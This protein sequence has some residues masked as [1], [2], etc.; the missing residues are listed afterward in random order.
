LARWVGGTLT[1]VAGQIERVEYGNGTVT[2]KEYYTHNYRLKRLTTKDANDAIL[3]D[4][5]YFYDGVGNIVKIINY[6]NEVEQGTATEERFA[7]DAF[8]RL[9]EAENTD[10]TVDEYGLLTYQYDNI[11]NI[12]EKDGMAYTY[13]E[14]DAG[15]HAVT[16]MESQD[17]TK[18]DI[19]FTYDGNGNMLTKQKGEEISWYV[20]DVEN[21]LIE[22]RKDTTSVAFENAEPLAEYKYDGDG[23]RTEKTVYNEG[24]STTSIYIGSLF[25]KTNN[26]ETRHIYLGSERIASVSGANQSYTHTNHLG[27][28]NVVTNKN[29]EEIE[30]IEYKPY[31]QFSKHEKPLANDQSATFYFTGKKLDDETGLYFLGG[32]YYDSSLG[33]FITPD[34]LVP[35]PTDPQTLNRYSYCGGNPVNFTD[36]SGHFFGI[37]VAIFKV[38]VAIGKAVA[39]VANAVRPLY[40][41]YNQVSLIY[42]LASGNINAGQF[43]IGMA[44]TN[45]AQGLIPAPDFANAGLQ[46]LASAARGAA[47]GAARAAATGQD[48]G[49][50]ALRSAGF[51]AAGATLD[52]VNAGTSTNASQKSENVNSSPGA[53]N[54]IRSVVAKVE[55][56]DK[57]VKDITGKVW[58]LPNTALGLALGV[59]GAPFVLMSGQNPFISVGDNAINIRF[60]IG[61]GALT[62]GNVVLY[63]GTNRDGSLFGPETLNKRTFLS[64]EV[65]T[66]SHER[67]HTV[68]AQKRGPLYLPA[69]GV[70]LLFTGYEGHSQE[71][72]ADN[73]AVQNP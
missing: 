60:P 30:L 67:Q 54:A 59:A 69:Y 15:P 49:K 20:Y 50:A 11:G 41:L 31:G 13:G 36:P 38:A 61:A 21:R 43:F 45:V 27:S 57:F 55:A 51:S 68:Q 22:V 18:E 25:E 44:V 47:V 10:S 56:I 34:T 3:Q 72:E 14:G 9:V 58:A 5:E 66:G 24:Q 6:R 19:T 2:T 1:N 42:N 32:R 28:T 48:V 37:F 53:I 52:V 23:G 63:A 62:L 12:L 70:E 71:I 35:Y 65:R 73:Y 17:G 8:N 16:R 7:Y 46:I 40:E 4:L 64:P 26:Q 33:K 39:A 29:G